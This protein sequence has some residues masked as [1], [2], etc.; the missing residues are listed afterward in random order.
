MKYLF[1]RGHLV[2]NIRR[3]RRRWRWWWGGGGGGGGGLLT[4]FNKSPYYPLVTAQVRV[5]DG[6]VRAA[7]TTATILKKN[8]VTGK[9]LRYPN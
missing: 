4:F 1:Q 9:I 2:P 8:A 6:S 5:D 3:R 7:L